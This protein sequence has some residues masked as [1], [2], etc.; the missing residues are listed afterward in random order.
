MLGLDC[1]TGF[2]LVASRGY[3]LVVVL[4][5]TS[6]LC[7]AFLA[8]RHVESQLSHRRLN[9]HPTYWNHA[10]L[11]GSHR[12]GFSCC[13]AWA[14]GAW[15]AVA[16]TCGLTSWGSQ[17]LEHRLIVIA[18]RLGCSEA[19]GIFP[20]EGSNPRLLHWQADSLPLSHQGIR[21]SLGVPLYLGHFLP[22]KW[23]FTEKQVI[24]RQSPPKITVRCCWGVPSTIQN[25]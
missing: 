24:L 15:A 5:K 22:S 6:V 7:L 19:C 17:V 9:P 13:W 18:H 16:A 11:S 23:I 3:S 2:S 4:D 10:R 20:Y 21:P 1:C 12:G 8:T 14:L 25:S